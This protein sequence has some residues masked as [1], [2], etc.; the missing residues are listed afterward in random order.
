MRH[1][2]R[3]KKR[4]SETTMIRTAVI[5]AAGYTG[6]ETVRWLLAHPSF[7]LVAASSEQDA[8]KPLAFLY[9][10]LCGHTKLCFSSHADALAQA[11]LQLVFLAV[12]HTV[13]MTMAAT[14]LA[15]NVAVV[16]LSADF[17]LKDAA[18]YAQWYDA[19][20]C[21]P[22]LLPHAVYG[23]PE[24]NRAVLRAQ[25][26]SW[27]DATAAITTTAKTA[28]MP[29]L[30]ANPG[31]YPTATTLAIAP[32]LAAGLVNTTSPVVVNAISGVSGAGRNSTAATHFCSVSDDLCAYGATTHRHTPE[33]AQVL[34]DLAG[35]A[36]HVIF[37]PHLA[38][39]KR[40]MVS[41]VVAPLCVSANVD[42]LKEAYAQAY[43]DEPFVHLL[44]SG[45]MP[46][47]AAVAGGNHAQVGIAYDAATHSLVASCALDNLGKG[48]ASQAIQNANIIFGLPET[49]GLDT[50]VPL[51]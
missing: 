42:A 27:Q 35:R 8:G 43:T 38:P 15:R 46:H 1:Y 40:G 41:T 29:P 12:P 44:P 16:D 3:Y 51:V 17:R 25:A 50:L 19:E 33:I 30:V 2:E 31:C 23:L 48:A 18:S 39:L 6:I 13:A 45:T 20:H 22:E 14:L 4:G 21:A 26:E 11:E 49:E 34:S 9:P 10:S 7:K 36:L 5:G 37:T 28:S 24:V 32:A 47:S